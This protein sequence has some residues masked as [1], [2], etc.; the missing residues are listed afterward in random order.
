MTAAA[1]ARRRKLW[2]LE[3][4]A[5]AD[6][7]FDAMLDEVIHTEITHL[8]PSEWATQKRV[9]PEGLTSMPGPF[10]WD[11]TPYWREVLDCLSPA[12]PVRE[13]YVLKGAQIGYTVAV[14]ENIIGY[15][16]D[17]EPGPMLYIS[18]DAGSAEASVE[19]RVDRM[20]QSAG[21]TGKIF[22]QVAKKA[23]KKSGD[24]K[25]KKEFPGGFLMAVGPNSGAKLRSFSIRYLLGD[26][27]DAWAL[28]VGGTA[29]D[30]VTAQEGDPWSLAVRR[31][32]SYEQI[33]KILCGSTPLIKQ[34]SRIAALY[35]EGDARRYYVPCR[36]CGEMQPL[37]WKQIKYDKD[38]EGR[39]VW[40]SVHYECPHCGHAWKNSDKAYF[41]TRGEWR[42]TRESR[43][44]GVR[45]YHLSSLY[46]PVGMRSWEDICEEWIKAQGNPAKLR[47]FINTVLGEPYEERG[48]APPVDRVMLRR[49][50]YVPETYIVKD[51]GTREILEAVLPEGPLLVTLGADVQHDRIECELVAWGKGKESWSLGYHIL[52]GSTDDP[53]AGAWSQLREILLRPTHGGFPLSLALIDSGDQA[54]IVYSFVD[55]YFQG[56]V[57]PS[58]GASNTVGKGRILALRD[59][60]GYH[61]KRI[62]LDEGM[63]KA[64]FYAATRIGPV[65]APPEGGQ[66]PAGYCHFPQSYDRRY[67]EKLYSET[68][69]IERT[70]T[71]VRYYWKTHG[72][73]EALDCRA[74]ALGALYVLASAATA[75]SDDP[76]SVDWELFW[77]LLTPEKIS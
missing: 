11:V 31:T 44:P 51:D 30:A 3:D 45:S 26:E 24:T 22:P 64:E 23:N 1:E 49:Q 34:T 72:R 57:L 46:S 73:N 42:P 56:G 7:W 4:E 25:N 32:D 75:P 19:L 77:E 76:S 59:N 55:R 71:G 53:G 8:L 39:L 43:R 17:C 62:D 60:P 48:D 61:C 5:R 66:L 38:P 10:R 9:L 36:F 12:S 13:V 47:V 18:G 20:I 21:L 16:I 50:D 67:F 52:D 41:L 65:D 29:R 74:Y 28:E 69:E 54:P 70:K 14:L 33:R 35:A 68:H 40:G 63:L 2:T 27:A 37:E 58:K 15:V 6:A